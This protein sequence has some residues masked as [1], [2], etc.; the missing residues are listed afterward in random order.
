LFQAPTKVKMA[1]AAM[2][3]RASGIQICQ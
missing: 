2:A 1:T 3:E